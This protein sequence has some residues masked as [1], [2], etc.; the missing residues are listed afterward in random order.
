MT[1]FTVSAFVGLGLVFANSVVMMVRR[2]RGTAM[3]AQGPAL[4]QKL[5]TSAVVVAGLGAP[6]FWPESA[7]GKFMSGKLNLV[8]YC[9]WCYIASVGLVVG[10]HLVVVR[11]AQQ[12]RNDS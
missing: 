3:P 4:K 11:R 6:D 5:P 2:K 10:W 7:F 9:I 8:A 1:W 12:A